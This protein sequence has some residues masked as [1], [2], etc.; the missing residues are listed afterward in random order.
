MSDELLDE[1][2]AALARSD[3]VPAAVKRAAQAVLHRPE[4]AASATAALRFPLDRV[5]GMGYF[6]DELGLPAT[7]PDDA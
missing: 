5:V 4:E 7:P 1:L 2:R 6:P 3:P